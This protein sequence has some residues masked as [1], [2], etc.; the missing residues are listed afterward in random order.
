MN[1]RASA[2]VFRYK[3]RKSAMLNA[4]VRGPRC[5]L[6]HKLDVR[7]EVLRTFFRRPE[8]SRMREDVHELAERVTD[9]EATHTPWLA[10]RAVL[11][12][13][14]RL[15]HARED[16]IQVVHFD[17]QIGHRRSG[18]AFGHE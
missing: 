18:A 5:G 16:L 14:L 11:D 6:F 1:S 7:P 10:H 12:G 8:S 4:P 3:K 2:S 17:G 13:Y 9:E 15:V